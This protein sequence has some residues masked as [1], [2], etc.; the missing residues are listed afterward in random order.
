M[1]QQNKDLISIIMPAYHAEKTLTMAVES[2]ISQTYPNW[3]LIIIDDASGD[4]T[5]E[6]ANTFAQRDSRIRLLRNEGNCGVSET[7]VRGLQAAQGQWIALLD[8]DDAWKPDKLQKQL[9]LASQTGAQLVFTGS[10]FMRSD[11]SNINWVLQVPQTISY[12]KLLKQNLISNSSVL[13]RKDCYQRHQF[14]GDDLHEDFV[15]WLGFLRAGGI[16]RGINEPLLIYRVSSNSKSGNKLRSAAM[17]W[18]SYRTVGLHI[19]AAA[20]YMVWY[21]LSGL[22][23]H[24]HLK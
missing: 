2:V 23:K 17:T 1:D 19:L 5:W 7:R 14:I 20:Y 18:R 6:I 3:E 12:R 4:R 22:M 8:S 13:V 10:A 24:R 11:G 21:T 16:A 15:C 9:T